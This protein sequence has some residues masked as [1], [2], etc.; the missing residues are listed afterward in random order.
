MKLFT[1]GFTRKSARRFF[2]LLRESGA[3]QIVDVR[4]N[5]VSQLAGFAKKEDL[6]YFLHEICEIGYVHAPELAPT[7]EMLDEFRAS[8]EDPDAPS[9]IDRHPNCGGESAGEHG[10]RQ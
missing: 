6:A 7:Q 9:R 1:I 4:L 2:A 3:K 5:N 8:V 10:C